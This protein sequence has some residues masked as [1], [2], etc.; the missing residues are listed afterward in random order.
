[1]SVIEIRSLIQDVIELEQQQSN[2]LKFLQRHPIDLHDSLKMS[3][4]NR[5]EKLVSFAMTYARHAPEVMLQV[6]RKGQMYHLDHI[7][8]P[9]YELMQKM[10]Y[11]SRIETEEDSSDQVMMVVSAAYLTHRLAE[12]LNDWVYELMGNRIISRDYTKPNLVVHSILGDTYVNQLE[13]M[14]QQLCQQ[15]RLIQSDGFDEEVNLGSA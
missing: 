9:V 10:F 5:A 6:Y 7:T 4:Q 15:F 11:T 13:I 14:V 1:M 2:F 3:G 8:L 12:E